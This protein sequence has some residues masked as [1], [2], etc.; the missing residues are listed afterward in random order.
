MEVILPKAC[1]LPEWKSLRRLS[2]PPSISL[3][4]ETSV[5][6]ECCRGEDWTTLLGPAGWGARGFSLGGLTHMER[7]RGKPSVVIN[8]RNAH[9]Q[10]TSCKCS[11]FRM[12]LDSLPLWCFLLTHKPGDLWW[13]YDGCK[14]LF[15]LSGGSYG[16][17][18]LASVL[19]G[20]RLRQAEREGG[21]FTGRQDGEF[22][23]VDGGRRGLRKRHLWAPL[24][25]LVFHC[26]FAFVFF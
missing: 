23:G 11:G 2:S 16:P 13:S 17:F 4:S 7:G 21:T 26:V 18:V 10:P 20:G 15:G 3:T 14:H 25:A 1:S 6:K 24:F 8:W 9:K 19:G 5:R 22:A 12:F